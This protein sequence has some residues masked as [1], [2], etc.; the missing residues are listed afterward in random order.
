MTVKDLKPRLWSPGAP[1]LYSLVV[2][3]R[4]QDKPIDS[5][6]VRFGFRTFAVKGGQ[7][8]L[9][10]HPVFL[11]GIAINPPGR[12]VPKEVGET[13]KFAEDYVRFMR[14]HNVNIIRLEHDAEPWFEVCDE[15]GMMVYQGVY[16]GPPGHPEKKKK[17][18]ETGEKGTEEEEKKE[19]NKNKVPPLDAALA[20]YR[21]IFE[22]Y[23]AHPSIVIYV[24]SNE[25]PYT[26]KRGVAWHD[27]LTT[28]HKTLSPDFPVPFIGNAGYG[29][30]REG[31]I[32]DV[33]RYWGWYYNSHLTY[34]NLRDPLLFGDPAKTKSQPLTFSECVGSFTGPSGQF[35]LTFRKQLGTS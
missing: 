28:V 8:R 4:Q 33:H 12:G 23:L 10:G 15:L 1:N 19:D 25:L 20:A 5:K 24:L 35:N 11:R 17:K 14:K 6:T 2:E 16:G 34:Y 13:R 31:D 9:N 32:N 30:G 18:E 22:S 26:G 29:Q 21:K 27:F 7:L 3:A